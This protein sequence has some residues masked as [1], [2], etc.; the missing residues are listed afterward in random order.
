MKIKYIYASSTYPIFL[1]LYLKHKG[2]SI[3]FLYTREKYH[4]L[5][6]LLE[7]EATFIELP[8]YWD[9][10]LKPLKIK[11]K[12][13]KIN[14]LIGLND[15][16]FTHLQYSVFLFVILAN[17][18]D[19]ARSYFYNFEPKTR[20]KISFI[21]L[22]KL[23]KSAILVLVLKLILKTF[24]K[25]DTIF[26]YYSKGFFI[27]LNETNF[28]KHNI[29]IL[30]TK[31]K[32]EQIQDSVMKRVQIKHDLIG[33][34][35]IGQN[36]VPQKNRVYTSDSIDKLYSFILKNN[37]SVK[38]HPTGYPHPKTQK[39][40]NP[41]IPSEFLFNSIS[42]SV[43]SISST[44]LISASNFY[45]NKSNVKIICLIYLVDWLDKKSEIEMINRIKKRSHN[46]I[47]YPKTYK[48]L[49]ELI[50]K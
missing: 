42:G 49:K 45:D 25:T 17:R 41:H 18:P 22:I 48:E 13:A 15:L 34:L 14:Y 43:I 29:T 1:G 39:I 47:L 7:V 12:L 27:S 8:N 37:I 21:E 16:I 33:N 19:K 20:N 35:Y 50:N 28:D 32:F 9:Y 11:R 5:F 38:P 26:S 4:D 3:H 24:Y 46:N 2:E 44:T 40:I 23:Y 31:L 30:K 6:E 36:E 10:V